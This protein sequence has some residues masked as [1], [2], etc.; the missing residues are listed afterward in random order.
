[1]LGVVCGNDLVMSNCS[2]ELELSGW[3][4]ACRYIRL[5]YMRCF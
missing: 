5:K 2:V 3:T 1:M 4:Y